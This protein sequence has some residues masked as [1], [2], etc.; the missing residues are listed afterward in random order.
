MKIHCQLVVPYCQCDHTFP[1]ENSIYGRCTFPVKWIELRHS[2]KREQMGNVPRAMFLQYTRTACC[3]AAALCSYP[4]FPNW[5]NQ[6]QNWWHWFGNA[7][8]PLNTDL[9]CGPI[10][11][12]MTSD[13]LYGVEA[14]RNLAY[15]L[16][17][18]SLTLSLLKLLDYLRGTNTF[19]R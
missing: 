9:S 1:H 6:K 5:S 14:P 13:I 3:Y 19:R 15:K 7:Q 11:S 12:W 17:F 10:R 16:T 2:Q 18:K 8:P 4:G